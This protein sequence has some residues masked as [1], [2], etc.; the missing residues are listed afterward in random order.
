MLKNKINNI[1]VFGYHG[2]YE[3]EIKNGQ[4]FI[5]NIE[6]ISNYPN[7]EDLTSYIDKK[8]D[9]IN[10]IINYADVIKELEQCFNIRR[11]NLLESLANFLIKHMTNVFE[12]KYFKITIIKNFDD[13]IDEIN[14]D[15]VE[16]EWEF[17]L[18]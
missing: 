7:D 6:Y 9:N 18:G 1:K 11:F 14:A 10:K 15:S 17:N 16:L 13:S 12:F 2:V 4:V 8:R 3:N 5:I